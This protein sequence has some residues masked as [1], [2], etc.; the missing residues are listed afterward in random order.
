MFRYGIIPLLLIL[1][2]AGY[3]QGN[4]KSQNVD[5][6]KQFLEEKGYSVIE[7]VTSVEPFILTEKDLSETRQM[8]IWQ[9]Q[10][11]DAEDFF[12][13]K[14]Y[15]QIFVI[16]NHPLDKY[17]SGSTNG[18]GKTQ[19]YLMIVDDEIIGGTSFPVTEEPLRGGVY[20]LDGKTFEE[21]Y[22]NEN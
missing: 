15:G 11:H 10:T 3:S 12:G 2:I 9:V 6:A 5:M 14:I 8:Q 21:L 7:H 20:S 18:L 17:E 16:K 1:F 19:V 4:S 13:K 22:S